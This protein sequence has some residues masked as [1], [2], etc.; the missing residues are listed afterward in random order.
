MNVSHLVD[1]Q[2]HG[3]LTTSMSAWHQFLPMARR[4]FGNAHFIKFFHTMIA[5]QQNISL[6]LDSMGRQHQAFYH[7]VAFLTFEN[8]SSQVSQLI[9]YQSNLQFE[10]NL[11][12]WCTWKLFRSEQ[13]NSSGIARVLH[14]VPPVHI[15]IVLVLLE[16]DSSAVSLFQSLEGQSTCFWRHFQWCQHQKFLGG[17]IK[18]GNP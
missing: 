16:D 15:P 12:I 13:P 14:A 2:Q 5:E 11:L 3:L 1:F 9:L 18:T 6:S 7:D 17:P 4:R 8:E 10:Y